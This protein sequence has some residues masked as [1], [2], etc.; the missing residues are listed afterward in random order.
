M[1]GSMCVSRWISRFIR[2]LRKNKWWVDFKDYF[3][4]SIYVSEQV[5][6]WI[7]IYLLRVEKRSG[8]VVQPA[9]VRRPYVCGICSLLPEKNKKIKKDNV[10]MVGSRA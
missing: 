6:G 4:V 3:F 1:D 8:P 7:R 10:G 9:D 5:H 2:L